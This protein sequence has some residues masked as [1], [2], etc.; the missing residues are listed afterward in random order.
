M[1]APT[2]RRERPF[3]RLNQ[4]VGGE[5]ERILAADVSDHSTQIQGTYLC[6]SAYGFIDLAGGEFVIFSAPEQACNN[7]T[8]T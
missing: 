4:P 7:S 8:A 6:V 5:Y 2:I 1:S 3:G